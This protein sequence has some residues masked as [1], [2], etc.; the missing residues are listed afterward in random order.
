MGLSAGSYLLGTLEIAAVLAAA[1]LG[2]NTLRHR[3]IPGVPQ[4]A[5]ALAT[6]V[7]AT[8]LVI[9][10]AELLGT[11]GFFRELPFV[12]VTIATGLSLFL[13]LRGRG[14]RGSGAPPKWVLLTKE[15]YPITASS[16]VKWGA[17]VLAAIAFAH[18]TIGV[19]LRLS[20]GMTGFDSTWY[21]GPFAAG[22]AQSGDT[23]DLQLIA[24]QFLA[25]FYPQNSELLHGIGNLLYG[26]DILS[27]LLNLGWFAGC[28]AAAW[29]I[30]RP[31]GAAPVSLA[32]VALML[33]TGV[34]ADQAGEARNDLPG[35]FFLLA[36]IAIAVT[37]AT[38]TR[39]RRLGLGA[40]AICATAAGLAAGTKV[41]FLPPAIALCAGLAWLVLREGGERRPTGSRAALIA[42]GAAL[43]GGGYWY[44]RNLIHA[45]NPVPQVTD[46]GPV[47]LPG[48]EQPLGGREGHSVLSY[49]FD[50]SVW[51]D[52]LGP[53]LHDGLGFLWPA[54]LLLAFAGMA[55]CLTR[56]SE[57]ALRLAAIVG[58]V[59]AATWLVA[60]TSASGP[61]GMPR[62]FESGL[63]YLAPALLLGAALA[64][65]APFMRNAAAQRGLLV[66]IA[67]AFPFADASAGGWASGY[68]PIAILA[69]LAFA[70]V[71]IVL[72]SPRPLVLGPAAAAAALTAVV[73]VSLAGGYGVQRTYLENRYAEPTFSSPGLDAAFRWAQPLSGE[74]IASNATRSYPFLGRD[75]SNEVRFPGVEQPQGGFVATR[76][77]REWLI[78]LR[79]GDFDYVVASLDRLGGSRTFAPQAGW[80]D[81]D[82]AASI[83]LRRAPT[84]VFRLDGRP[85]PAS[86]AGS[87]G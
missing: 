33:N 75:L 83:V 36:A 60:P 2:A 46:I 51:T 58:F 7:L 42:T 25:W 5:A 49:L 82:P 44:L 72:T 22:F 17:L 10:I 87:R 66:A 18:F 52:W 31:F 76:T 8:A 65:T 55:A 84:V 1:C 23:F 71:V 85:D 20:T 24:P 35:A 40:V 47:A 48:P 56:G 4:P 43:L 64:P 63:R 39:E 34:L 26:R 68:L 41:N 16:W 69:G 78:A 11:L 70:A 57:P 54:L 73:L 67:I 3:L 74:R 30:G 62:G 13:I 12:F 32:G 6:T 38:G 19:R 21:H 14:E 29:A 77:C 50:G 59:A 81:A 79:D 53:G 80:T 28:L 61:D 9:L 86:C 37:V 27:P 45:G 15:G